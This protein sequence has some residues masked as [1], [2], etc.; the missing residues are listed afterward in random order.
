MPAGREE[1]VLVHRVDDL[2]RRLPT[3]EAPLE[4]VLLASP[5]RRRQV[6]AAARGPL[7][8]EQALEDVDRGVEGPARRA[9]LLLAVPAAV[10]HLLGE[11][12]VDDALH[13]LAEVVADRDR[14]AVDARLDLAVEERQLVV[15]PAHVLADQLDRVLNARVGRDRAELPKHDQRRLRAGPLGEVRARAPVPV[16]LLEVEQPGGPAL[17]GDLGALTGD[18]LGRLAGQVTH[19][20]PTDRGVGVEQPVRGSHVC[21]FVLSGCRSDG[22][23]R[24]RSSMVIRKDD[25]F[26]QEIGVGGQRSDG[27]KI[28]S[29]PLTTMRS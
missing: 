23:S 28:S 17:G 1:E 5:A 13:V 18:H 6:R 9:V 16:G 24:S 27:P 25:S 26:R 20:L 4:E 19:H 29:G 3:E 14:R 10:G 21:P 15:L 22:G 12:P 8:L 11:E 7:V 2:A